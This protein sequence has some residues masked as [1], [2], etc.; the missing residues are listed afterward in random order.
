[1]NVTTPLH[2]NE[3]PYCGCVDVRLIAPSGDDHNGPFCVQC[4][5]A[6]CYANG[7]QV[8]APGAAVAGWN[9]QRSMNK[10]RD[11]CHKLAVDKKWWRQVRPF[12]EL[13]MLVNTELC[14]LAEAYRAGAL[15]AQCDKPIP[16]TR[17]DEELADV[18][19]R[20]FDIAGRYE[21]D[22]DR[23]VAVKHAY[24]ATRPARHGGKKA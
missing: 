23:A 20:V 16:L 15:Q 7:P 8:T 3:C 17:M 9:G 12:L 21:V 22:L 24:N 1:M 4:Q 18:L 6:N 11:T 19:I 5:D 13:L 2:M 10:W 14:E